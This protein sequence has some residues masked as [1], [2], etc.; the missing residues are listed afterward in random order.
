M[1]KC[2]TV[3]FSL[4]LF[5]LKINGQEHSELIEFYSKINQVKFANLNLSK[6]GVDYYISRGAKETQDLIAISNFLNERFG[7]DFVFIPEKR[8]QVYSLSNSF[9]EFVDISWKIGSFQSALGAVGSY[10]FNISFTFC[11]GKEY[12]FNSNINVNGYTYSLSNAIKRTL[13][14]LFPGIEF[15]VPENS[16]K[17]KN[18]DILLSENELSSYINNKNYKNKYEGIYKIYNSSEQVSF[19]EIAFIENGDKFYLLSIKNKYFKD[20]FK[21]GE[22]RG[23]L[24]KTSVENLFYGTIKNVLKNNSDITVTI[25]KENILEIKYTNGDTITFIKLN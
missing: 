6:T 12:N 8:Q 2:I 4:I 17:I 24:L 25:T 22:I 9:C 21:Y 10:P 14:K 11:D 23:E 5:I 7:L 3:L 13:V 18:G 15:K 1:K 16:L 19:D 20:D